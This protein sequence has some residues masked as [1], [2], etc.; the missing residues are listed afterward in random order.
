MQQELVLLIVTF[1]FFASLALVSC[2][3][4]HWRFKGEEGN[5]PSEVYKKTV[6]TPVTGSV[7]EKEVKPKKVEKK[8]KK[9]DAKGKKLAKFFIFNGK[10]EEL[11][12]P[13]TTDLTLDS[14]QSSDEEHESPIGSTYEF[15]G[16]EK[17]QGLQL[18]PSPKP[19]YV[20]K[21]R[22]R[23]RRARRGKKSPQDYYCTDEEDSLFNIPSLIHDPHSLKSSQS[24]IP[25]DIQDSRILRVNQDRLDFK[26]SHTVCARSSISPYSHR[27]DRSLSSSSDSATDTE[28]V[29]IIHNV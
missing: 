21:L 19:D 12:T 1:P 3:K 4:S 28:P 23:V 5:E 26:K 24:T 7:K 14:T 29:T 20:Q 13:V 15:S 27:M 10:D 11:K 18:L 2:L 25:L 16:D 9:S 22:A 17:L 8:A 6:I